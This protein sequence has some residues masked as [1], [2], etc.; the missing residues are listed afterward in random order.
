MTQSNPAPRAVA[1]ANKYIENTKL[2]V[3]V[4]AQVAELVAFVLVE[5]G[6]RIE[7]LLSEKNKMLDALEMMLKCHEQLM[8]GVRH[9]ACQDYKVLNDGPIAARACLALA[10]RVTKS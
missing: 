6:E 1:A 5:A 3:E 9:I 8:P 4:R 7:G 2:P 10:G